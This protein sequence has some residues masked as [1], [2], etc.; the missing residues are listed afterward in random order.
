MRI[1]LTVGELQNKKAIE[2]EFAYIFD[3]YEMVDVYADLLI[4]DFDLEKLQGLRD[5]GYQ[6]VIV[7]V[8]QGESIEELKAGI[9]LGI[10]GL[11]EK[12]LKSK[13]IRLALLQG[14]SAVEGRQCKECKFSLEQVLIGAMQGQITINEDLEK[15]LWESYGLNHQDSIGMVGIWLGELYESKHRMVGYGFARLNLD[16]QELKKSIVYLP[17]YQMVVMVIFPMP[18]RGLHSFL[19]HKLQ[20]E[21]YEFLP[22]NSVMIAERCQGLQGMQKSLMRI[23]SELD[24]NLVLGEGV[25]INHEVLK[26]V[27]TTRLKYPEDLDGKLE[28]ALIQ[29]D[30]S[31]FEQCFKQLR[32]TCRKEVHEPQMIKAACMRYCWTVVHLAKEYGDRDRDV[33]SQDVL[34][35]IAKA[36]YWKEIWDTLLDFSVKMLIPEKETPVS[37]LVKQAQHMIRESYGDGITLEEIAEQLHVTEEYLSTLF[38]KETGI[39]FSETIR[40]HRIE[41]IKDLLKNS[42]LRMEQIAELTGY[43]D[44]KYMSRVF[45]DAVG[46]RPN[47]FRKLK[48]IK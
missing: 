19:Q 16:E 6:G 28:K 22:Q 29:Q 27:K 7:V 25:L 12:P 17:G 20:M 8:S 44:P 46:I 38:R 30:R 37:L 2:R 32:D 9:N 41:K 4:M 5:S 48:H 24:W 43:T 45:K 10:S 39:T 1:A 42:E 31:A 13:G 26:T 15:D 36:V 18:E 47:E 40:R 11:I 33:Y 23:I 3:L 14:R 34:A 21:M 35:V